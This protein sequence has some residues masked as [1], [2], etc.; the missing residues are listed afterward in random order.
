VEVLD[1]LEEGDDLGRAHQGAVGVVGAL[2]ED[3]RH[4]GLGVGVEGRVLHV[5][6]AVEGDQGAD[7][8]VGEGAVAE[9]LAEELEQAA[10]G[11]V[12]ALGALG[13]QAQ[14]AGDLEDEVDLAGEEGVD[15]DELFGGG[16]LSAEGVAL[17]VG[18]VGLEEGAQ[19]GLGVGLLVQEAAVHDVA[20]VRRREVHAELGG[21]AVLGPDE[22]RVVGAL[23]ELL[24]AQ[25][26]EP[27]A[28]AQ[29]GAEGG[30]EGAQAVDAVAAV[31]D[32]LGDLV[33]DQEQ[34]GLGCAEAEHVGDGGDGLFGGVEVGLGAGAAREPGV[35]VGVAL[36]VELVQ[37]AREVV[38]GEG[39][40]AGLRPRRA[41]HAR[42]GLLEAR[43]VSVALEA[44]L[45]VGDQGVAGAV[46]EALLDLAQGGGVEVLVVA[47]DAADVEDDRDGVDL[48]AQG[49]P[50]GAELG[51]ARGEVAGE[52]G[53][54]QGAPVGEGDA[55]EGEA[56]E[57]GEAGLSGAVEAG[58]PGRR[59]LRA[60]GFVELG[61][62]GAQEAHVLLVDALGDA[63]VVGVIGGPAARDDVLA[64]LG[65]QLLGRLLVEVH[66]GRDVARDV[67][68]EQ[69]A[70]GRGGGARIGTG[71]RHGGGLTRRCGGGSR[72][73]GRA[74]P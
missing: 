66:D 11:L 40:G 52:P 72:C 45:E 19:G 14:G 6:D 34:R 44:Q 27:G 17:E 65:G 16:V 70:D 31:D 9:E 59:Q 3:A 30:G 63:A 25:G 56:E 53:L 20:D 15:L 50:G 12:V 2:L 29:A 71:S 22:E 37:D 47:G 38:L 74:R 73:R 55:V 41:E 68:L 5:V 13:A 21:E 46:A 58:D 69:L 48:L 49:V 62:Q 1:E 26:E 23:V 42:G 60:A 61:A 7:G 54:G 39:A 32:V 57:L 28:A 43:V 8:L 24:L 18:A 4:G 51:G 10:D 64:D 67:R 36:G 35:G 33:D